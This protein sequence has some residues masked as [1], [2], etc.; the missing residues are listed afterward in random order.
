LVALG[1]VRRT[2]GFMGTGAGDTPVGFMGTGAG[3]TQCGFMGT[4][5]G[6]TQCGV[7][8]ALGQGRPSVWLSYQR[9]GGELE[10]VTNISSTT[11]RVSPG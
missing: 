2:V 3:E 6:E 4:G 8:W 9:E 11:Q 5:A 7:P 10:S 1:Q